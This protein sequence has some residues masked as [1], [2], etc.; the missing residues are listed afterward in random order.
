MRLHNNAGQ[1]QKMR[2]FFCYYDIVAEV[3]GLARSFFMPL[4]ERHRGSHSN[5]SFLQQFREGLEL[6][7]E[8][9][10]NERPFEH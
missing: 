7:E 2:G 8:G 5:F 3:R 6:L 1:N 10:S 4:M 9:N